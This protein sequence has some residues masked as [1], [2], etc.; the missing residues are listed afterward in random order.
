MSMSELT[1]EK[2]KEN[3]LMVIDGLRKKVED[4]ILGDVM[5]EA[6]EKIVPIFEYGEPYATD[7][8][9]EG[10]RYTIDVEYLDPFEGEG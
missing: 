4:H 8:K 10:F 5:I 6:K 1:P 9:S 3:L 2:K 7:L